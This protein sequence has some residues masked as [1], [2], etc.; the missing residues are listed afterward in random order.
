MGSI[1]LEGLSGDFRTRGR[2]EGFRLSIF[3]DWCYGRLSVESM[4]EWIECQCVRSAFLTRKAGRCVSGGSVGCVL[5]NR[6]GQII[7]SNIWSEL[8][9]VHR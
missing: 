1:A 3:V 6:G 4:V 7:Q 8:P 5:D 9:L 2:Y